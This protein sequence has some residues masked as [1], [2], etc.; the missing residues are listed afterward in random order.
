MSRLKASALLLLIFSAAVGQEP[1]SAKQLFSQ[2]RWPELVRLIESLALSQRTPDLDYEYGIA[3]AQLGRWQDARAALLAGQHLAP[4]DTRFPVELAGV[5]FKQRKNREATKYLRRALRLDRKD[6]YADNFLA[7]L[8]FLQ[9]NTEAALKYWN[10]IGKPQINSVS[11]RPEPQLKPVLLDHAFAFSPAGTMRLDEFRTT[12]ARFDYLGVFPTYRM[13]LIAQDGGQF[14]VIFRGAER[15]GFGSSTLEALLSTFRGLPFQEIDPQYYNI[16]GKAINVISLARWDPDKRR[17]VASI[18]GPLFFEPEWRYR[19]GMDLRNENWDIRNGFTGPAPLLAA[20]NLRREAVSAEIAQVVGWR[21]NWTLGLELSHRDQR[22]VVQGAVLTPELLATGYQL[23]QTARI[24]YQLLRSPEHR[25]TV[26]TAA[27][28][29]VARLW[30]TPQQSFARVQP[31]LDVHWFPQAKGD[32]YE[33]YWR[34]RGGKTFGQIPFDELLMLGLERDNN[35][36]LRAHIGTR[37]GR[38]GSA[39][40]GRD[41]LLENW[42]TDKNLYSNGLITL[43]LGPFFDIGRMGHALS[44]SASRKWLFDTGAQIKLRVLGIGATFIYGKDLRTGNNAFF[45]TVNR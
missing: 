5:A 40:L 9:G 16:A 31:A 29:D 25:V 8:Y 7:S 37:D 14:D 17:A 41:Y 1:P 23:K 13:D 21:W 36:P 28:A 22:N 10:R 35:L 6:T 39:P 19:L 44:T 33:T 34:L 20:L 38:K 26:T 30:S 15:H 42:E 45:A 12:E 32:D 24:E 43:K 2:Q 11:S 18:S 27:E 3:L 4:R